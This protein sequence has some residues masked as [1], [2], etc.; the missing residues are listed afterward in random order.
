MS[1]ITWTDVRNDAV[2]H[3]KDSINNYR[4]TIEAHS[5]R[6]NEQE[7]KRLAIKTPAVFTTLLKITDAE[8]DN[9]TVHFASWVLYRATNKDT[10][11]DGALNIISLLIPVIR[12]F[13]TDYS[14]DVENIQAENLYTSSLDELNITLWAVG[15]DVKL[16]GTM[17]DATTGE[18]GILLPDSLEYFEG[19]D[20]IAVVGNRTVEGITNLEVIP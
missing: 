9:S 20:S 6:F 14:Y 10:L 19:T 3:I 5:G 16:R 2:S 4:I 17:I 8:K 12:S 1:V 15:W 11:G 18:G 7:I 13:N